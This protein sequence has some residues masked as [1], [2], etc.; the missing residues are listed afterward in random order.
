M[1]RQ[2]VPFLGLLAV[3]FTT[4]FVSV[5]EQGPQAPTADVKAR[6]SE[7]A[8]IFRSYGTPGKKL[9]G[10]KPGASFSVYENYELLMRTTDKPRAEQ[11]KDMACNSDAVLIVKLADE[12]ASLNEEETFIF[13]D[14]AAGVEEILKNNPVR[15]VQ[16][17]SQI[18]VTRPGGSMMINGGRVTTQVVQF[19]PFLVPR[20][21]LLYL[22][23]I[24]ATDSYL[25]A[26]DKSFEL[27]AAKYFPLTDGKRWK[28]DEF[29]LSS[30]LE[31]SRRSA[32]GPCQ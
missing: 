14:Y 24:S 13:T 2:L 11:L 12:T 26:G 17:G 31:D 7:H 3:L 23:Y 27:R 6:L 8:K 16:V 30:F 4:A 10:R 9:T 22:R 21:Y 15:P 29:E 28:A 20:R 1:N 5:G 32:L 19:K 18:T 25:A